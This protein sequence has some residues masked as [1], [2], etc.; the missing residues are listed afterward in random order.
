MANTFTSLLLSYD[1]AKRFME[2]FSSNDHLNAK[3]VFIGNSNIYANSDTTIPDIGDTVAAAK[4]VWDNMYA[5]K[6]VTGNDVAL[7]IPRVNWTSGMKFREYDDTLDITQLITANS[8]ANLNP[9]YVMNSE[10]NVYKCLSNNKSNTAGSIVEP[11]GDYTTSNG[12]ITTTENGNPGHIW[13]YLFNVKQSNKFLTNDWIP[14]PSSTNALDYGLNDANYIEG[15]IA[16]IVVINGGSGYR[17]TN[18]SVT[19]YASGTNIISVANTANI[20]ANMFVVGPGIVNGTY[21]TAVDTVFKKIT[22][23]IPV[24]SNGSGEI[25]TKTRVYIDGDGNDD[26]ISKVDIVNTSINKISITSIGTGYSTANVHI[27]GTGTNASARAILSPKFGHGYNPAKELGS[28]SVMVVKKIGEVDSTETGIIST[29][30]SFRQYGLV[31]NPYK[32]NEVDPISVANANTVISQTYDLTM[33]PGT[34]Y[35]LNEFV[36]Q[37]ASNTDTTFAG[38]VHAQDSGTNKVRLTNVTG[39]ISVGSLLKGNIVS[40]VVSDIDYPYFEPY[41]GDVLFV[42]NAPKVERAD[43]QSENIKIVINF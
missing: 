24:T 11:I 17:D 30:T 21:I 43:G 34:E 26:T 31:S 16:N 10:Y 41:S 7:V 38:I 42:Q 29:Q 35:T 32:Y 4:T 28:R 19:A 20:A 12:F 1:T 37:G 39:T 18:V 27:Y 6:R 22:L 9:M 5:A 14:I 25:T 3:Y 8:S 33:L 13:K 15:A 36:Y 2:D 40:K 23:S